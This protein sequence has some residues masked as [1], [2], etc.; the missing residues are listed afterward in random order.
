MI[1]GYD[2]SIKRAYGVLYHKHTMSGHTQN[3]YQILQPIM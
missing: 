3:L 2:W 1:K